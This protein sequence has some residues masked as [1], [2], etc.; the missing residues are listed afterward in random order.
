M[1]FGLSASVPKVEVPKVPAAPAVPKAPDLAGAVSGAAAGIAGAVSGAAAGLAATA[2]GAAEGALGAAAK[3]GASLAG[4]AGALAEVAVSFEGGTVDVA[5]EPHMVLDANAS[6][7]ET[8]FEKGP[9]WIR[10]D[11]APEKAEVSG[12]I[13]HLYVESGGY[14]QEK[15]IKEFKEGGTRSVDVLFEE[16]PMDKLF[17]LDVIDARGKTHTMFSR[18]PY[19]D[20]RKTKTGF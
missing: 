18:V 3:V 2:K 7:E 9:V 11:M 16:A 10:V 1:G 15:P 5:M 19:G 17:T 20:L 14:D 8:K 12:E 6:Y 13:L 4:V